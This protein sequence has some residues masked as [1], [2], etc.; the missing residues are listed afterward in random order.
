MKHYEPFCFT[1][2]TDSSSNNRTNQTLVERPCRRLLLRGFLAVV[3]AVI[4]VT[5]NI[6]LAAAQAPPNIPP[7]I[8][9]EMHK[10]MAAFNQKDYAEAL[11]WFQKVSDQGNVWGDAML[12]VMYTN[13]FG[14]PPNIARGLDFIRRAADHGNA[15]AQTSLGVM[16]EKGLG[17]RRD[18]FEA[19]ALYRKAADQGSEDAQ[20]HLAA[21]DE[22]IHHRV[23]SALQFRCTLEGAPPMWKANEEKKASKL[24]DDCVKNNLRR[25]GAELE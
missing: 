9:E 6:T 19:L 16:Y 4:G 17:V 7:L 18:Y 25:L 3:L 13:G 22:Y 14:V 15:A 8:R 1:L 20:K 24:Y 10:G 21:L 5:A 11:R 12:G 23:P 2:H